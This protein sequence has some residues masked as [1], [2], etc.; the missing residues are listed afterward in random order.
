MIQLFADICRLAETGEELP[1]FEQDRKEMRY[2]N[3]QQM[4]ALKEIPNWRRRRNDRP[5]RASILVSAL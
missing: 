4:E 3:R 1:R 2:F 5:L